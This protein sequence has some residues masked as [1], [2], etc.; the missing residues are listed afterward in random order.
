MPPDQEVLERQL[1]L[2]YLGQ[3]HAIVVAADRELDPER[4]R[5]AFEE[6]FRVRYGHTMEGTRCRS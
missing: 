3:E 5:S 1:E 2:R 6:S 4:L